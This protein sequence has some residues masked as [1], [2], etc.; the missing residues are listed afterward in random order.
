MKDLVGYVQSIT[1]IKMELLGDPD[2]IVEEIIDEPRA[3][4][5]SVNRGGSPQP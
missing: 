1:P 2:T 3:A 5:Y 4:R